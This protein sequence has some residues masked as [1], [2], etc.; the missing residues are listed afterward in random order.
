MFNPF[1]PCHFHPLQAANCCRNSR[2]VVD[3]N[4]LNWVTNGK[5][6][7]YFLNI[8]MQIFVLKPLGFRKLSYF[9]E[10]RNEALMHR[11]GLALKALN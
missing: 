2:L 4:D 5:I 6:Y 1:N 9:S 11:E 3:E 7:C 10:M 8:S